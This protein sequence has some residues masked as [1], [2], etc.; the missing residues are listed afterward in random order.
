MAT[1]TTAAA[2]SARTAR[3]EFKPTIRLTGTRGVYKVSSKTYPGAFYT[4]D[5]RDRMRPAC[6]CPAGQH[7]FEGCKHVATCWHVRACQ[8]FQ[9]EMDRVRARCALAVRGQGMAALQDCF[10]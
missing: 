9:A 7:N 3:K 2:A 1:A 5:I 10:G 4:T 6:A 8:E